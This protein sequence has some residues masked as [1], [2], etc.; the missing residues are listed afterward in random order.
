MAIAER[1]VAPT[2]PVLDRSPPRSGCEAPAGGA[3]RLLACHPDD[4]V[5]RAAVEVPGWWTST[6]GAERRGEGVVLHLRWPPTLSIQ[7]RDH[8]QQCRVGRP[9]RLALEHEVD[10][11]Q[12]HGDRA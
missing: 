12:A 3:V 7:R 1:D 4:R 6:R 10:S 9:R 8:F 5:K 11:R 2:A